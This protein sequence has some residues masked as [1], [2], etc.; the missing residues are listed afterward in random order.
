[1]MQNELI[2]RPFDSNLKTIKLYIYLNNKLIL[3]VDI[4]PTD[5]LLDIRQF[6]SE[7]SQLFFISSY[8]FEYK[9][10]PLSEF[11]EISSQKDIENKARIDIKIDPY[12]EKSAR[13][14]LKKVQELIQ[15][16]FLYQNIFGNILRALKDPFLIAQEF[17]E[18]EEKFEGKSEDYGLE[19]FETNQRRF[20]LNEI[21][22]GKLDHFFEFSNSNKILVED[23]FFVKFLTFSNFNPP[24]THRKLKGDFFY[25]KL[26]TLE[27]NEFNITSCPKGFYINYSTSNTY[28][29]NSRDNNIFYN[30]LDLVCSV[31]L[32]CRKNLQKLIDEEVNEDNFYLKPLNLYTFETKWLCQPKENEINLYE[33]DQIRNENFMVDFHGFDPSTVRDW[34][35]ELQMCKDLPK[36]DLI[37]RL[38]KDKVLLKIHSDFV[39]AATKGAKG[40]ID[41]FILPLNPQD[42][43]KQQVYVYNQIFFSL[44]T[45]TPDSYT[46]EKGLEPSPTTS[47]V[48]CDLRNLRILHKLDI[49]D[50][51]LLNTSVIDYKG[52]RILAQTII[53]GILNSEQNQRVDFGSVDEGQTIHC[54]PE[55]NEIMKKVCDYFCLDKEVDC[56]DESGNI[57]TLASSPEVKGIKSANK[58]KFI[59]DLTRLSPRDTNWIGNEE[60][61]ICCVI[62]P[63]LISHFIISKNFQVASDYIK[64]EIADKKERERNDGTN[65]IE[66][67]SS[68]IH[69]SRKL[70]FPQEKNYKEPQGKKNFTYSDYINKIQDYLTRNEDKNKFKFN[71]NLY[72]RTKLANMNSSKIQEQ[73]KELNDLSSFISQQAIPNLIRDLVNGDIV[74]PC[75]SKSLG[76]LFHNHGVNI[77]YIGK[78]CSLIKNEPFS[79]LH[80]LLERIM[81]AKSLKH[82]IR[83]WLTKSESMY[84]AESISHIFNLVFSPIWILEKLDQE[85]KIL[86]EQKFNNKRNKGDSENRNA[87]NNDYIKNNTIGAFKL[88]FGLMKSETMLD[89]LKKIKP[90]ELWQ[91]LREICQKRYL[92]D[93]P[94]YIKDFRPFQYRLTKIATLRDVCLSTG[95]ILECAN[96]QLLD[97]PKNSSKLAKD[98]DS[99]KLPFKADNIFD[100]IPIVKHLDPAC[101]DAKSQIELANCL[102]AEGKYEEALENLWGSMQ[103]IL[104]I[105]GPIHKDIAFCYSKVANIYYRL[106][107]I[108]QAIINH[109]QSVKI[110]E[111][112]YGFDNPQTAHGYSSLALLHY[113]AKQ[114]DKAFSCMMKSLYIFN[115]IGGEF[116]PECSSILTNMALMYQDLE[117]PQAAINCLFESLE[118]NSLIYNTESLKVAQTFQ[119]LALIHLDVQDYLKSVEYQKKSLSILR[120]NLQQD[121]MRIKDAEILLEK[122]NKAVEERIFFFNTKTE[123]I[124]KKRRKT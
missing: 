93:L 46:Q 115:I 88:E 64:Q 31:S 107:E 100:A 47:I 90:N 61:Y 14:H 40:I 89:K 124:R 49:P 32:M 24:P 51:Y 102:I 104:N 119:S 11:V 26:I 13:H 113:Y 34:N 116:H 86:E 33:F 72:T 81:L 29:P 83:E 36:Q 120:K 2:S 98:N 65:R 12:E 79:F 50:L 39:E 58:K 62:R 25:L 68:Q 44:G 16:P 84:F 7:T 105:Y 60:D 41:K 59:L 101:D 30:L 18:K 122:I 4:Y 94:E 20:G 74:L 117:K 45:A 71:S 55:L 52:Q 111:K 57:V 97:Y 76:E 67:D 91:R 103:I 22:E 99:F 3:P 121:D 5:T 123:E 23:L 108:T 80:I 66:N 35:E 92:Y 19:F 118:R 56:L 10:S 110:L 106:G 95:I 73:I 17:K 15:H 1:M 6:L 109:K 42:E 27:S 37:Q 70:K 75:D 85:E 8:H 28:N 38:N 43:I 9:G 112:F 21:I 69:Y 114:Y 63:E 48:N 78:V 53:P 54:Q 96:Y 87:S 77:R 82:Y